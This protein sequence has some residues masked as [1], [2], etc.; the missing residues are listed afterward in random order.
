MFT[1][2]LAVHYKILQTEHQRVGLPHVRV[3]VGKQLRERRILVVAC[4]VP[5]TGL[6]TVV[7]ERDS[8]ARGLV[9]VSLLL[10]FCIPIPSQLRRPSNHSQRKHGIHQLGHA[11]PSTVQRRHVPIFGNVT[12]PSVIVLIS[13]LGR[14]FR[15]VQRCLSSLCTTLHFCGQRR[16]NPLCEIGEGLV[17]ST[18]LGRCRVRCRL[19]THIFVSL[20]VLN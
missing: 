18:F 11:S 8:P 10:L 3:F 5:Q 1:T 7:E 13:R 6:D 19:Y 20:S 12:V 15:Q 16:R 14:V 4:D 9:R 17:R 2:P